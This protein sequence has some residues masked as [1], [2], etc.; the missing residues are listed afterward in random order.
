MLDPD[1]HRY[2]YWVIELGKGERPPRVTEVE[3]VPYPGSE[4]RLYCRP[5]W[6]SEWHVLDRDRLYDSQED[7]EL[8]LAAGLL[9][10]GLA[11]R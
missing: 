9:G 4:T 3:T 6:G 10:E 8:A 1:T 5:S 2:R 7:A 11:H